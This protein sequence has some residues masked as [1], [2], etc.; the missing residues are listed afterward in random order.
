VNQ[1]LCARKE[2]MNNYNLTA[3]KEKNEQAYLETVI[4]P[5]IT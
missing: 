4:P 3:I 1:A 2:Q 5:L